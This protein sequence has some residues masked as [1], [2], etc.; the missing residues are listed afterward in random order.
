A[1]DAFVELEG[2]RVQMAEVVERKFKGDDVKLH[3]LR[4]KQEL[5]VTINLNAAWPFSMQANTYDVEPRYVLF[6]GLLFQP[7][8]RNFLE[9][10]QIEDLRVRFFYDFFI[11]D[12][13]YRDHPE[14]IVLSSILPD[15]INTYLGDFKGGILDSI[16]GT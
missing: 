7:L 2:E 15:P 11:S 16:N 12:E 5:D 9:A 10:Y 6:G 13:L 1:S 3:A 14:V 8:S 4:N